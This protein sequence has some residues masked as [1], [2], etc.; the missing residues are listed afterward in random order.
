LV[1]RVPVLTAI[2]PDADAD[3]LRQMIDR[4]RDRYPDGLAVLA[5]VSAEGKPTVIAASSDAL[6]KRGLNAGEL[7]KYVAAPLGGSGGGRPTLAQAGGKD[8]SR[9]EEALAS[10]PGWVEAHLK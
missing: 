9:L 6:V 1:G 8:A 3:A 2:L 5:T 10:V 4:F 7:V